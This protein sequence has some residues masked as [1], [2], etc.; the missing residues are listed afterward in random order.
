P[1]RPRSCRRPPR[2]RER[3]D[4]S[5]AGRDRARWPASAP[6]RSR[7]RPEAPSSRRWTAGARMA[8]A[9]TLFLRR[10]LK[11]AVAAIVIDE[12]AQIGADAQTRNPA[13]IDPVGGKIL[14]VDHLAV[15]NRHRIDQ[16]RRARG[17]RFPP[18]EREAIV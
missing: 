6:R 11:H 10:V 7:R 14:R 1:W 16:R 12:R 15:E 2:L 9:W 13:E 17:E 18:A 5:C 4:A 8:R 3:A